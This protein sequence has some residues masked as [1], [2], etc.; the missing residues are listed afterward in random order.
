MWANA[1][2][3][4]VLVLI[5]KLKPFIMFILLSLSVLSSPFKA[6][7]CY[8]FPRPPLLCRSFVCSLRVVVTHLFSPAAKLLTIHE[9]PKL[10][11]YSAQWVFFSKAKCCTF[12]F[13]MRLRDDCKKHR[14]FPPPKQ[15]KTAFERPSNGVQ[16]LFKYLLKNSSTC[17]K[18]SVWQWSRG[19]IRRQWSLRTYLPLRGP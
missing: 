2:S 15:K 13:I 3:D 10:A 19:C 16:T 4:F 14:S 9:M 8:L 18:G 1:D 12:C 6:Q 5:P 11:N 17:G 7:F